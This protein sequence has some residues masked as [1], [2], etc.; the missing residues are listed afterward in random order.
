M[1]PRTRTRP[2]CSPGCWAT[3][4]RQDCDERGQ[5]PRVRVGCGPTR[6]R[7]PGPGADTGRQPG[8]IRRGDRRRKPINSA[9]AGKVFGGATIGPDSPSTWTAD[10][11][12]KYP[13]GV[14][15]TAEGFPDFRP[16][17]RVEVDV[18]GLTGDYFTDAKLAN[19]ALAQQLNLPAAPKTPT[20]YVRHHV[21]DSTT[22]LLVPKDL[23]GAVKHTGGAALIRG[24]T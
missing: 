15:F 4:V 16:Y 14:R 24:G 10:L 7:R 22:M 23:H 6:S 19:Q 5:R 2:Q 21:E 13:N 8:A 18:A 17:A 12:T 3:W 20:G 11:A 9:Y 1:Y